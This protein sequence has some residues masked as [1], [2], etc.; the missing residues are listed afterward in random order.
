MSKITVFAKNK[1]CT[2]RL[3][4]VC[5]NDPAKSVWAHINSLRWGAGRGKKSLDICGLIACSDCHDAIDGRRKKDK[6]GELL[7]PE[8]VRICAYQGHF[9]SLWMLHKAGII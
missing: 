8:F 2:C 9:E 3:P 1:S 6:A 7:D 5:N 4:S